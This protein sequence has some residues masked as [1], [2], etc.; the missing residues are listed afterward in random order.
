MTHWLTLWRA[1]QLVGVSRGTIE[2]KIRAGALRTLDGRIASDELLRA[3]PQAAVP[4]PAQALPHRPPIPGRGDAA[5]LPPQE[6]LAQRLFAQARELADARDELHRSR[7]L[8]DELR[9]SLHALDAQ[10]AA[11]ALAALAERLDRALIAPAEPPAKDVLAIID[12]VLKIMSAQVSLRPSGREFLVEG[13]ASLLQAALSAGCRI[14]YGCADGSCGLCKARVVE[15][16]VAQTAPQ[17]YALSEAEKAQGYTLLCT[18]TAASSDLVLE[19]LEARG[20]ED[21]PQQALDARVRAITPLGGN[22]VDLHLLM[23]EQQR[24]RFLSGQEVRLAWKGDEL[25]IP[26]ANCPC[27]DLNLHFF[28]A[29][30]SP[31]AFTEAVFG[32]RLNK[33]D[34]VRVTGP[35][36]D[37][38][39]RDGGSQVV[40]I[41]CDL[42]M[43]PIKGLMEHTM[44]IDAAEA[45]SLYW[46]ATRSDGHFLDKL[47]RAWSEALDQFDVSLFTA[48]DLTLGADEMVEAM[49]ADLFLALCDIYVAGPPEFAS[50]ILQGL[51]A[52]GVPRG[53]IQV[54]GL[55]PEAMETPATEHGGC[56]FGA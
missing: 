16:N 30:E 24:L 53:Q 37:F 11:P 28:L 50:R 14:N 27:D 4:D 17:R 49:Q 31:D 13:R 54:R 41:A 32:G 10:S 18:H 19:A 21:L 36:G 7:G 34:S 47:C 26:I 3:F 33:G 51:R 29:R 45:I 15:G 8:L 2:R 44:A 43:A 6:V 12:D 48:I 40:F 56:Q 22:T 9:R 42:G 52:A 20:P 38:V 55:A 46:L 25:K 1:S 39:L 5:G 23:P 35:E